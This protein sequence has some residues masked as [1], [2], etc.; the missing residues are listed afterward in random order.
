MNF[1][2]EGI[3]TMK[4]T[5]FCFFLLFTALAGAQVVTIPDANFKAKL[6]SASTSNNVA[7]D[8]YGNSIVID[9]NGDNNIQQTEAL[10]VYK[11]KVEE[12]AISSLEGVQ[13]F[14]NL[15]ELECNEN[16]LTVLNVS[17][18]D[19]L[20]AVECADNQLTEL[21]FSENPSLT[22]LICSNNNLNYI[23]L[24]NGALHSAAT[25]GVNEW[26]NNTL[27]FVCTD[28]GEVSIVAA[29]AAASGLTGVNAN[30]YCSF[31][32]GG[33]YNTIT[34]SVIFDANADGCDTADAPQR[35]M[36]IH[37]TDGTQS[38]TTFTSATGNY[39]FYPYTGTYT[40][41]PEFENNYFT[42]TPAS[43][44][45]AFMLLDNSVQTHNFCVTATPTAYSDVEIVMVPIVHAVPGEMAS[46]K[47][48]YKNKGNQV[49]SGAVS[50]TWNTA[51]F[52][53]VTTIPAADYAGISLYSWNYTNLQ[54]FE[55]REIVINLNV[56]G[57]S[58]NPPVNTGDV[59]SF[60]AMAPV[61]T[62]ALPADNNFVFNQTVVSATNPNNIT[63]IEGETQATSDIGDY[64]HYVVNFKNTG[65][66][67]VQNIVITYPVD[68][69]DFDINTLEL[70]NSSLPV[71]ATITGNNAE[72]VFPNANL[73]Q[74]KH[75]NLLI[76]VKT[77]STITQGTHVASR[78]NIYYDYQQPLETN[79]ATTVFG[80]L[81]TGNFEVDASVKVYPNPV[82]DT[83]IISADT[84]ITSIEMY[85]IQGRL[86]QTDMP[87][88]NSTTLN[89]AN[90]AT[91][92]YFVK[93]TTA[94]GSKI[95]KVIKQ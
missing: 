9:I 71:T 34:G 73:M 75:G 89:I 74:G 31:T 54:P 4:T 15:R 87:D 17:G 2:T 27:A 33:A 6:L 57:S 76:K 92:I 3:L 44:T 78:A 79:L 41:T 49:V 35:F 67:T 22:E 91:G 43:A 29:I 36:K 38:C 24:K 20:E 19:Y 28:E 40:V 83:I 85:D 93:I 7:R 8:E 30:G 65:T 45:A 88:N 48:V 52:N 84:A 13:Y 1:L 70:L 86:L 5:I 68:Q 95:E 64:L 61:G 55:S 39:K 50:C 60:T 14:Y 63:C 81:S 26:D 46:Y 62:D 11:L 69:D 94:K 51:L 56:N 21:D 10:L 23:N 47:M 53:N 66:A 80:E 90:R 32:P 12:A 72:F 18:L 42:A 82:I 59:I 58:N 16:N 77:K 37:S 25:I